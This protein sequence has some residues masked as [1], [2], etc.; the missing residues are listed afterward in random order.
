MEINEARDLLIACSNIGVC[1]SITRYTRRKDAVD[2]YDVKLRQRDTRSST[3][4]EKK[5]LEPYIL[6]KIKIFV[7]SF[8]KFGISI[9]K[10]YF[11][12]GRMK[13]FFLTRD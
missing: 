11:M 8:K 1:S 3:K 12:L 2:N 7:P 10:K 9:K 4:L 13:N 5:I 6:F